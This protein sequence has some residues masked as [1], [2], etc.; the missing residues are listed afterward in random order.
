MVEENM[1]PS[2]PGHQPVDLEGWIKSQMDPRVDWD[3]YFLSIAH[4]V[5]MRGECTRARVGAIVVLD[6]RI[7]ATGYNG[8]PAGHPNCFQGACPRG[9]YTLEQMPHLGGDTNYTDCIAIHAE[10]NALLQAGRDARGAAL[11]GTHQPCHGCIKLM[12][13]AGITRFVT[14]SLTGDLI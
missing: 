2:D 4:A 10:A 12:A 7:V 1:E 3:T 13:G 5:S 8:A 14:P 6:R 9:K 11:Y